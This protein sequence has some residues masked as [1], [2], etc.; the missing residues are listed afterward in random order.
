MVDGEVVSTSTDES[1]VSHIVEVLLSSVTVWLSKDQSIETIRSIKDHIWVGFVVE[2]TICDVP[3]PVL[4]KVIK[5][6]MFNGGDKLSI[7]FSSGEYPVDWRVFVQLGVEIEASIWLHGGSVW[8][9]RIV[10]S[11]GSF[12]LW[13][14]S[15]LNNL[16]FKINIRLK[17]DWFSTEW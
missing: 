14:M 13:D 17:W 1:V 4:V 7:V 9:F 11:K 10:I 3:V 8:L 5:Y 16:N 15:T 12:S 2:G 6:F